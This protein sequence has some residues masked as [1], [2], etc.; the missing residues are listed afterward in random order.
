M[1]CSGP[2]SVG[3]FEF[4][5]PD[6]GYGAVDPASLSSG[7]SQNGWPANKDPKAILIT[8]YAVAL[9]GGNKTVSL[10]PGASAALIQMIMWWDQNIEPVTTLGGYNYRDIRGS[11]STLSNHASG[12]AVDINASK[13]PLGVRGT[14]SAADALRIAAKAASLGLRWGGTY[15]SR[16][17]EMHVELARGGKVATV[18]TA[19]GSTLLPLFVLGG[20]FYLAR[21][22]GWI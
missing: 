19:A 21:R 1:G 16:P 20:G 5:A 11:T 3:R 2:Y 12:T 7:T 17:D 15:V 9:K 8:P 4:T 13:H 14:V 10:A 22:K 6:D 18:A